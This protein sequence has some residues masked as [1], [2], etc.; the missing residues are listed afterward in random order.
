MEEV[1]LVRGQMQAVVKYYHS[2]LSVML[3]KVGWEQE[4]GC[5]GFE[6]WKAMRTESDLIGPGYMTEVEA[7]QWNDGDAGL[8]C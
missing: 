8:V 6:I 3:S 5:H 7:V 4:E 1:R 2:Y